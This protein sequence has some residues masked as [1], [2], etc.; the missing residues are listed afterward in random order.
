[1][2]GYINFVTDVG[3]YLTIH[4]KQFAHVVKLSMAQG[5]SW[6]DLNKMHELI[7]MHTLN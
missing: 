5:K 7:K 6:F 3:M 4:P 1:M 2:Q